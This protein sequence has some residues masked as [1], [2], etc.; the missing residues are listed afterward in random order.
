M[1]HPNDEQTDSIVQNAIRKGGGATVFRDTDDLNGVGLL[2]SNALDQFQRN[3]G[4][5]LDDLGFT[6]PDIR[7]VPNSPATKVSAVK[8]FIKDTATAKEG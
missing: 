2:S 3:I 7:A 6:L 5:E 4:A 8:K 1:L